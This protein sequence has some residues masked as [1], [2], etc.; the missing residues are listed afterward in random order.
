MKSVPWDRHKEI[1][2]VRS[3]IWHHLSASAEVESTIRPDAAALLQ[4]DEGE[5]R[6]LAE[7]H[8]LLSDEVGE[9]L[10]ELPLLVR[11]LATTTI[12]EEEQSPERVRGA[13][14]W[15][16]TLSARLGAG[17]PHMYVTTPSR[18]AH[19]TPENEL[20]VS[21]MDAIA[22]S[23]RRLGIPDRPGIGHE[24]SSRLHVNEQFRRRRVLAEVQRKR[25]TARSLAR[26]R[27]G[28]NRR[29]YAGAISSFERFQALVAQLQSPAIKE[30]IEQRAIV[31]RSDPTLFEISG[32]FDLI[33]GLEETGWEVSRFRLFGIPGAL[34]LSAIRGG[35][36]IQLW[37]QQTPR[38]L[39]EGSRYVST[40]KEHAFPSASIRSQRPDFVIRHHGEDG[41]RRWILGEVKLGIKRGVEDSARA[42]LSDL[43]S[44]RRDF[45]SRLAGQSGPYGLGLAWGSEL[46]PVGSEILLCTPDRIGK[47]LEILFPEDQWV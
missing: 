3:R 17:V 44:Y 42:A 13:I 31:T 37:Y 5:I 36:R 29:R 7:M 18:R 45:R 25:V 22:E 39:S 14:N 40:L 27:S 43:L 19:Q 20:L 4:L 21:V 10:N 35:S 47:A 46:E 32:T 9:L 28:R 23:A 24:I 34:Q 15:G 16:R 11:R 12:T 2:R 1:Q 38:A 41:T 6:L 8:F 30:A 26:V 33:D